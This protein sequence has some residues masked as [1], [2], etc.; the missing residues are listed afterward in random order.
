MCENGATRLY[1]CLRRGYWDNAANVEAELR[2]FMNVAGI[3][4][5]MPLAR[6]VFGCHLET[7]SKV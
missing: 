2:R 3:S 6:E 4:G 5:R 1:I 7:P